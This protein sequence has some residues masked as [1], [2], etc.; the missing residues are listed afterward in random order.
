MFLIHLEIVNQ[1]NRSSEARVHR[2]LDKIMMTS[3]TS[4]ILSFGLL[5]APSPADVESK[6]ANC[7]KPYSENPRYWQYRGRPVLLLGGSKDDN[8]FQIPELKA[9]LDLLAKVGGNYIRNTMSGRVDK[10]FEVQAFQKLP[11]GKYDL[12]RWNEE[13]WT[14]FENLLRWTRERDIIIQIE[15]WD[16]FD[17]AQ[18]HWKYDPYNPANNINYS[19]EESGLAESYPAPAWRDRQ[20]FFHSIPGMKRY[21]KKY[22][23]F[24]KH[25]ELFVAKMLSHSLEYGH[26]L[27]CMNNETSTPPIWGQHWMQFIRERARKKGVEV[28]VTDMFDDAWKP[29]ASAKLRQAIENPELYPFIDAS[30][31]NSRNFGEDHWNRL[32]W[33]IREAHRHPRP[34]NHTKIYGSGNTTWGSGTPKDGV[35]RFWRDI[36]G[37]SASAR[38]H[39]DGG[40]IGLQPVAQACIRAARKLE[41]R[42]RIWS[43]TPRIDLLDQREENEAYL[44][45]DPGK[46]YALYFTDGGSVRLDLRDAPGAFDLRWIDIGSGE[47]AGQDKLQ[48]GSAVILT[49]PGKGGWVAAITRR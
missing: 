48:G 47:D 21:R 19:A 4:L 8:L 1:Y 27:Y 26:V 40:G 45:V 20:P 7:I 38:H 6:N 29:E 24:R 18:E 42:I 5:A 30:Q 12:N 15:V 10:G 28:Y 37:G 31:V 14:R 2:V 35:E 23:T 9:H 41:S 11:G 36:L 3:L 33:I 16:R 22:D 39:R 34:V 32:R 46:A 17:H 49:A 43:V 13:Y 25:Q 44:A